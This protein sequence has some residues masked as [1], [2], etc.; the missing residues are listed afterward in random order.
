MVELKPGDEQQFYIIKEPGRLTA[1]YATNK[2]LWFVNRI[3]GGN[4]LYGTITKD[5]LY[6][7]PQK[8]TESTEIHITAEVKISNNNFMWATVLFN[9]KR[10]QYKTVKEWGESVNNLVHLNKPEA[11]ALES[12]GDFLIADGKIKRFSSEA[13]LT[14]EFGESKGDYEGSLVDP[15]N[16][17]V[18]KNGLTFCK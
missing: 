12:N 13:G 11:H 5:G 3:E 9:G 2:V 6:K 14:T 8:A 15:L 18:G 16:V 7:A 1:A 4:K 10:P 17:I